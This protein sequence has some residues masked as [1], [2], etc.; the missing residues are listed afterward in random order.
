MTNKSKQGR[1]NRRT[2]IS[3][4]PGARAG[5]ALWGMALEAYGHLDGSTATEPD[6]LLGRYRPG[7]LV[8]ED[9]YVDFKRRNKH[10]KTMAYRA[11]LWR[12]LAEA[13]GIPVR[14]VA[15]MA[16]QKWAGVKR[17]DKVVIGKVAAGFADEAGLDRPGSDEADAVL[18]GAYAIATDKPPTEEI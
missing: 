7:L 1:A 10:W 17:G 18:I 5:Y 12:A 9:F 6:V 13:R 8:V 14:V 11:L 16:W 2:T 3:V 4:D 15:S